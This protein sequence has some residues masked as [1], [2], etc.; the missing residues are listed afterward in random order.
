MFRIASWRTLTLRVQLSTGRQRGDEYSPSSRSSV[1][2]TRHIHLFIYLC[3]H[4]TEVHGT[5]L[6]GA[7]PHNLSMH[8][9]LSGATCIFIRSLAARLIA[10][11][12]IHPSGSFMKNSYTRKGEK[13]KGGSGELPSLIWKKS[14]ISTPIG[15]FPTISSD[16]NLHFAKRRVRDAQ[17]RGG[18]VQVGNLSAC[19]HRQPEHPYARRL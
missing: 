4:Q 13:G 17:R 2:V 7:F 5:H 12:L 11:H 8:R 1:D 18:K 6:T 15:I 10:L 16:V 3:I 9:R 19:R 14:L